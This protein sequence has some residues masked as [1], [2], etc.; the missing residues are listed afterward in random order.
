MIR[1]VA[2]DGTI[3][4]VNNEEI[5]NHLNNDE[6]EID[7]NAGVEFNHK[8]YGRIKVPASEIQRQLEEGSEIIPE[9]TIQQEIKKQQQEDDPVGTLEASAE[10]IGRGVVPFALTDLALTKLGVSPERLKEIKEAHPDAALGGEFVGFMGSFAIPT[11]PVIKALDYTA[12][13]LGMGE[14]AVKVAEYL[15]KGTK[16]LTSYDPLLKV[17][18]KAEKAA[19]KFLGKMFGTATTKTGKVAQELVKRTAGGVGLVP[20]MAQLEVSNFL[21]EQILDNKGFNVEALFSHETLENEGKKVLFGT[22]VATGI[23]FLGS[24]LLK[25]GKK[26]AS[27]GVKAFSKINPIRMTRPEERILKSFGAITGTYLKKATEKEKKELAEYFKV[28]TDEEIY[29][30]IKNISDYRAKKQQYKQEGMTSAEI[31]NK[32]DQEFPDLV[33]QA[34]E[35]LDGKETKLTFKSIFENP[36]IIQDK[37]NYINDVAIKLM[38]RS[39]LDLD[40]FHQKVIDGRW[41]ELPESGSLFRNLKDK[42]LNAI[43]KS[44]DEVINDLEKGFKEIMDPTMNPKI[45]EKFDEFSM[46]LKKFIIQQ[47]GYVKPSTLIEARRAFDRNI[48]KGIGSDFNRSVAKELAPLRNVFEKHLEDLVEKTIGKKFNAETIDTTEAYLRNQRDAVKRSSDSLQARLKDILE[49]KFS[50]DKEKFNQHMAKHGK[51]FKEKKLYDATKKE[52]ER[53][54]KEYQLAR[55]YKD[56]I[57]GKKLYRNSVIADE[58]LDNKIAREIKNN[59]LSLTSYL[60]MGA[61]TG[62][63]GALGGGVGAIAGAVGGALTRKAFQEYGDLFL[64]YAGE[65]IQKPVQSNFK[66]IGDIANE[67]ID[68]LF[69]KSK[70]AVP[71][72]V[73]KLDYDEKKIEEDAKKVEDFDENPEQF[74]QEFRDKNLS[75]YDTLPDEAI[76]LEDFIRNSGR[77][78]NERNPYKNKNIMFKNRTI[79]NAEKIKFARY[80][81]YVDNSEKIFQEIRSGYLSAEAYDTLV[82]VFPNSFQALKEAV[83]IQFA[84]LDEKE[85]NKMSMNQLAIIRKIMGD[86]GSQLYTPQNFLTL[87]SNFKRIPNTIKASP[88]VSNAPQRNLT[89]QQMRQFRV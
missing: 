35:F 65:R 61:G 79:S 84:Q 19:E 44:A 46:N 39:K 12:R 5:L 29:P 66:T 49:T 17:S 81:N 70:V 87:Q 43:R 2:K 1:L 89:P 27:T 34:Q 22:A 69:L 51:K 28:L 47:G 37:N 23:P 86:G 26:V 25:G 88:K 11:L 38:D 73:I 50:G 33:G 54:D 77:F 20:S 45:A 9:S 21:S 30:E 36:R 41:E 83:T 52:Y 75:F 82:N 7:P 3:K 18:T 85:K 13:G 71:Y 15:G 59:F 63:G 16:V 72:S 58:L 68:P 8:E 62:I 31:R 64:A 76:Y 40:E 14:K 4:N 10:G 60:S 42:E 74:L 56:Y 78:L 57:D 6:Y 80:L 24:T 55:S 32:L 67:L 48:I 53:L